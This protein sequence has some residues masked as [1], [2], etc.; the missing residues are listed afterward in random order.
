MAIPT[1]DAALPSD[2]LRLDPSVDYWLHNLKA[3]LAA[4]DE[5]A[6][7]PVRDRL[8]YVLDVK[9]SPYGALF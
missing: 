4:S 7:Q 1:D 2:P 6:P 5:A 8:F 3:V 9:P